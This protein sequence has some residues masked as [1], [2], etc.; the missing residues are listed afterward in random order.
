MF[1]QFHRAIN[2]RV[3]GTNEHQQDTGLQP[4]HAAL[5]TQSPVL[6]TTYNNTSIQTTHLTASLKLQRGARAIA[7]A[8]QLHKVGG[9][10]RFLPSPLSEYKLQPQLYIPRVLSAGNDARSS[11]VAETA[12]AGRVATQVRGIE[13]NRI[14]LLY[15]SRCV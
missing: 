4:G 2:L 6:P 13:L 10:R 7:R 8:P 14:C 5:T 12:P 1:R 15:T 11:A 9:V 3:S